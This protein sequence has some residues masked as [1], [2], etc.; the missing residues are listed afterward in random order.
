MTVAELRRP[1]PLAAS[2]REQTCWVRSTAEASPVLDRVAATMAAADYS[3]KDCF[4]M[5]LALEE[6]VAN[7]VKHGHR[8]DATKQVRVRYHVSTDCVLA[9]VQDQGPGF[10]PADVPDPLAPE[11]LE[12]GCG[13]GLLLMKSLV[14]WCRHNRK[15]NCVTLC[16]DRSEE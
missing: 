3:E 9:E 5:R 7:A 10:N 16:K 1:L 6:A 14:T 12:R 4:G 11:N 15:G 13:R 2:E 8:G